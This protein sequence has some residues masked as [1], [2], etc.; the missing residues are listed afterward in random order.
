MRSDGYLYVLQEEPPRGAAR[1]GADGRRHVPDRRDHRRGLIAPAGRSSSTLRAR[2]APSGSMLCVGLDP[3]RRGCR[4]R[5]RTRPTPIVRVLPR[6]RR[7]HRRRRLRVQAA[8][9]LLRVAARRAAA[10]AALPLHPRDVSRCRADPRR[11][12]RRHR[13]DRRALRPRGVRPLRRPRRHGQPVPRHRFGRAVPAPRGPRRDRAVPHVATRA[14]TTSSRSSSTAS[15]CTCTSPG[16]SP[17]SG[18]RSASAGSSSA[19]PIPDE[20]RRVR[21]IVGDLPILVPGVGAQG[22]DVEATVDGRRRLARAS[23]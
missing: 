3:I 16:A 9:R 17:T 18:R 22:G 14:A 15:R 23:A 6:D 5:S 2:L 21:E 8:D 13:L 4:R 11:Q 1:Q 20:L 19:P 12:A 10:R 7:R